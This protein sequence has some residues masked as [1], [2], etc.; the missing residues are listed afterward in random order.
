MAV[1]PDAAVS[2]MT[3]NIHQR[4]DQ[5]NHQGIVFTVRFIL[6]PLA[7]IVNQRKK[8]IVAVAF[9][10]VLFKGF[11]H[12]FCFMVGPAQDNTQIPQCRV[13]ITAFRPVG[14]NLLFK[15]VPLQSGL[16]VI[17]L[18]S[19]VNFSGFNI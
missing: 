17:I 9:R 14:T 19:A 2:L 18:D 8:P 10:S 7:E 16:A 5:I 12:L 3:D 1:R 11:I 15:G 6:H 4:R 13:Q